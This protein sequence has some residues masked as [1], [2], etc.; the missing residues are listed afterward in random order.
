MQTHHPRKG[1]TKPILWIVLVVAVFLAGA[2]VFY[3]LST[4]T[5]S[6]QVSTPVVVRGKIPTPPPSLSMNT[7]AGPFTPGEPESSTE[8][9]TPDNATGSKPTGAAGSSDNQV[10]AP[11]SGDA[12]QATNEVGEQQ[13]EVREATDSPPSSD[14]AATQAAEPSAMQ[15]ESTAAAVPGSASETVALYTIQVGAYRAKDNADRQVT[16][17]L[18]KGYDA[19]LYEKN[20]TDRRA[21]FFVRF[22]RFDDFRSANKALTAFNKQEQVEGALVRLNPK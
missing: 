17:L 4:R 11:G 18:E 12:Q 13:A 21:W 22:G 14:T 20:E 1:E 16:Q 10:P 3:S 6:P 9:E 15:A 7:P 2:L 5:H 19:Y 8:A